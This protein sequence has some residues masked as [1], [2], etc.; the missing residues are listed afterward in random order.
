MGFSEDMRNNYKYTRNLLLKGNYFQ[1]KNFDP[2]WDKER[3]ID[4][5]KIQ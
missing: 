3:K 2:K 5:P 4:L 1:E